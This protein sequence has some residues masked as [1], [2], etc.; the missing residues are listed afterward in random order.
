MI[1]IEFSSQL[2]YREEHY[3]SMKLTDL[4]HNLWLNLLFPNGLRTANRKMLY[5]A[6]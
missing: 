2:L 3:L 6:Q 5:S 1:I 4:Y